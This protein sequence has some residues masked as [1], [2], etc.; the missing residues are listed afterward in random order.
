MTNIVYAFII[1]YFDYIWMDM[2][3]AIRKFDSNVAIAMF[4]V[5]D[6]HMYAEVY[7]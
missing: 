3:T 6:A 1:G 2:Y 4:L 5:C 7:C